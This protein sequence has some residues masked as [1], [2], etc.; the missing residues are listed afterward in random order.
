MVQRASSCAAAEGERLK[1]Y[2][3][4]ADRTAPAAS[5]A[6]RRLFGSLVRKDRLGGGPPLLLRCKLLGMTRGGTK[7]AAATAAAVKV[8]FLMSI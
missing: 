8:E 6:S 1:K 2:A 5:H 7:D 3:A 4:V